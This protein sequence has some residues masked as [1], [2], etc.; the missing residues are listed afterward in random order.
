[1]LGFHAIKTN[2]LES[3]VPQFAMA[4]SLFSIEGIAPT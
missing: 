3:Y 2:L 4:F 1:V